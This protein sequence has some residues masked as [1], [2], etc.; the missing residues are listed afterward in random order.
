MI[1]AA[2]RALNLIYEFLRLLIRLLWLVIRGLVL[3]L[4]LLPG[5]FDLS[6]VAFTAPKFDTHEWCH[7]HKYKLK[8]DVG[9]NQAIEV[10]S[11]V[12]SV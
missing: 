5:L 8:D 6:N 11:D 9:Q 4:S 3:D 2:L 10:T 7:N 1:N 12:V